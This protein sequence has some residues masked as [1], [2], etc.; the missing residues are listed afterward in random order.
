MSSFDHAYRRTPPWDIGRPQAAFAELAAMGALTGQFL[1]AGCGTG[2]H[3]LM[4]AALGL[5]S[6]GVDS[7]PAAIAIAERKAHE[8]RL[9]VRF[10][11]RDALDLATLGETFDTVVD[12]G[13]FHVF[14]DE[15]RARYVAGLRGIVTAGARLFLLCFSDRQPGAFG[16]RRVSRQEIT[17]S[18]A[19]GWRVD[20][21]DEAA[22][23]VNGDRS[24]RAWLASL[25]RR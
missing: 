14:D 9:P 12:S 24:A 13:L 25:T 21:I 7:S 11:V 15:D 18:F 6:T 1:D 19:D 3:A 23:E 17:T 16:P 4:A 2:E 5:D 20:A 8:R 10:I 22:F